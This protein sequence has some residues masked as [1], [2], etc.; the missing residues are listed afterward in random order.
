[1]EYDAGALPL[2]PTK[3]FALGSRG[4]IITKYTDTNGVS[5]GLSR[6]HTNEIAK[7]VRHP[8]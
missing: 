5:I 1:M 4:K 3:G 7:V 8:S 2:H 6:V